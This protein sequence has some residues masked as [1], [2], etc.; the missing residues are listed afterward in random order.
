MVGGPGVL[1][2]VH[3]CLLYFRNILG[4]SDVRISS[5]TM[6][7]TS[8][9]QGE[10]LMEGMVSVV[11]YMLKVRDQKA[12]IDKVVDRTMEIVGRLVT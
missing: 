6:A 9:T 7:S 10:E 1:P 5:V 3:L 2:K 12:L 8:G 11:E 4:E